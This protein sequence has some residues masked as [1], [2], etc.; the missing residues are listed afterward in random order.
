MMR[1]MQVEAGYREI[2]LADEEVESFIAAISGAYVLPAASTFLTELFAEEIE[3]YL[4][5]E[6]TLENAVAILQKRAAVYLAE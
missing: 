5:G 2:I 3:P 1:T 4:A 6:R